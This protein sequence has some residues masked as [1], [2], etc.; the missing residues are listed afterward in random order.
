MKLQIIPAIKFQSTKELQD[1]S[2]KGLGENQL[3]KRNRKEEKFKVVMEQ[4]H[5]Q[6][7]KRDQFMPKHQTFGIEDTSLLIQIKKVESQEKIL[8]MKCK[9]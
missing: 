8:I 9:K 4:D 5:K 6:E 2:W 3:L 7:T 1:N